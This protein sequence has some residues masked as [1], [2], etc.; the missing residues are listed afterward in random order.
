VAVPNLRTAVRALLVDPDDRVLLAHFDLPLI[1]LWA[2]PGGGLEPGE[3][4][5]EALHRELREEVGL[6]LPD[7][8]LVTVWHRTVVVADAVPGYD[9]QTEDYV[10]VPVEPF[11]P[12]GDLDDAQ[13]AAENMGE[14]RWWSPAELVEA[15][16]AN[17]KFAPRHLPRLLRELHAEGPPATP[18]LLDL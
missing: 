8:P 17:V 12:R 5:R 9:G 7:G 13:L 3:T 1:S 6:D 14:I 15:E 10:L 11:V 2:P 4:V 18:V 16:A